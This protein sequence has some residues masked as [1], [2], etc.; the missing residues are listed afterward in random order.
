MAAVKTRDELRIVWKLVLLVGVTFLLLLGWKAGNVPLC[1]RLS[2][3]IR[4][5]D[6]TCEKIAQ[7]FPKAI[8]IFDAIRENG[9]LRYN[10]GA[11]CASVWHIRSLPMTEIR[12]SAAEESCLAIR[13]GVGQ[14]MAKPV[15][16]YSCAV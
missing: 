16:S 4:S 11:A 5:I 15:A 13:N 2:H 7:S 9:G 3:Q 10:L 12:G 6:E 1:L 14:Q 8:R